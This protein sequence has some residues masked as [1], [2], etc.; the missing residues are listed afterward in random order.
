MI[1][2]VAETPDTV[3]LRRTDYEAMLCRLSNAPD[4][5]AAAAH[6][7]HEAQVGWDAARAGYLTSDE[8]RAILDGVP[9]LRVWRLKRG[10]RQR[11][12]AKEAGVA[13]SYLCEIEAGKKP[14]S[15]VALSRLAG[16][17]DVA[18]ADLLA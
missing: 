2:P 10:L 6:T 11:A 13:V 8:A 15:A 18:V 7:A 9:P 1:E 14:G 3:T 12:L 5:A 16:V 17:L 4:L